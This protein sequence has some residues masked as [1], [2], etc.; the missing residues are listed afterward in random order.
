[1]YENL[2]FGLKSQPR[3]TRVPKTE[4]DAR[5]KEV[6]ETVGLSAALDRRG[7]GCP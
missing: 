4:I 2:A 7:A 1:M 3:Q 6:A 5:V